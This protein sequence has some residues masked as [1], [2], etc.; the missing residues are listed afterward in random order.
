MVATLVFYVS[1]VEPH[2][3]VQPIVSTYL[4]VRE[5]CKQVSQIPVNTT[6]TKQT[7]IRQKKKKKKNK[8]THV[9]FIYI[10]IFIPLMSIK[11]CKTMKDTYNI[12]ISQ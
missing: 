10:F 3:G 1:N 7:Q 11:F 8:K 5:Q 12:H 4:F 6:T 9:L 2:F